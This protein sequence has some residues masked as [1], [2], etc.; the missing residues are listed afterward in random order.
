M[1]STRSDPFFWSGGGANMTISFDGKELVIR[2]D[3][4]RT[5]KK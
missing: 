5:P 4:P 1:L 3:A 2:L